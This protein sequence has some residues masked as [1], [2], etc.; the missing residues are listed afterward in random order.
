MQ[1]R[2]DDVFARHGVDQLAHRFLHLGSVSGGSGNQDGLGDFIVFG[3]AE[4]IH[5]HPIGR[6][7]AIGNHQ[8][9]AWA[10]DHVYAD[11]AKHAALGGGNKRVAWA[12]DFIDLRDGFG[13]VSQSRHGLCAANGENLGH[14]CHI[15]GRQNDVVAFA[16]GR[17]HNHD[18]FLHARDVGRHG[19]HHH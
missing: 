12:S 17:G 8:N 15:S 1:R 11:D 3:L 7:R 19:I 18:D 14:A 16:F 10:S 5:R 13:A 6:G 9:L 2:V 4:Q